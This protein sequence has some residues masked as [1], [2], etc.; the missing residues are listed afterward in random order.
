MNPSILES[1]R[2]SLEELKE[3][4]EENGREIAIL[5]KFIEKHA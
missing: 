2:K 5:E 1:A 3:Q 4:A